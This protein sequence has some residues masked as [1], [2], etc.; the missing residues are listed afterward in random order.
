MYKYHAHV[1]LVGILVLELEGVGI[2][3][4]DGVGMR[5]TLL[6][7]GRLPVGLPPWLLEAWAGG[8][9]EEDEEEF[10]VC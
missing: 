7:P 8:L 5:L 9:E 10:V 6:M 3:E 4:L 1:C 2:L